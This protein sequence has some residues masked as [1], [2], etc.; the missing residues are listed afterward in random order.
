MYT[1]QK[2]RW[3]SLWVIPLIVCILAASPL[4]RPGSH[5]FAALCNPGLPLDAS[6]GSASCDIDVAAQVSSGPFTL[7]AD[8]SATV[9]GSPFTL[10]GADIVADFHFTGYIRDHRGSSSGGRLLGSS[11]GIT[12]GSATFPLSLLT[13]N[14]VT[15]TNGTCAP[16]TFY[17]ATPLTTTPATVFTAGNAAHTIVVDGNYTAELNGQF[18]IPKGAANGI[19]SGVITATL[20]NAF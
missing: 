15:C 5:V 14:P 12:N 8:S 11:A 16:A 6:G 13:A 20:L 17:P 10:T 19:Y 2:Q 7:A 18:T 4:I 9:P 1:H 3:A